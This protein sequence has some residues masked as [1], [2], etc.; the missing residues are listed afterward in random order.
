VGLATELLPAARALTGPSAAGIEPAPAR[1]RVLTTRGREQAT[2]LNAALEAAGVTPVPVPAIAIEVDPPGGE[3]DRVAGS[4][5]SYAWVVVSSADGARAILRAA[6]RILTELASPRWAAIGPA[7]TTIL[8]REG[9]EIAFR[10]S[11]SQGRVMA[12][13]LPLQAG[14]R[15]LVVRGDLADGDLVAGLRARGAEVDDVVAYRTREAPPD[16][17]PLL[18][19]A[20]ERGPIDAVVFTSGSTVRGLV[21]LA[22]SDH[23]DLGPIPAV[24]IGPE[25][26]RAATAAG[27]RVVAVSPAQD[28]ATL[29]RTTADVLSRQPQEIT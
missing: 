13:E 19:R 6:E 1:S 25:T 14:D 20:L 17:R 21:A 15:V 11:R 23:L 10:P 27:F 7:T 18:R 24:C 16:S 12:G 5:N 9:V 29:A 8:E 28:A 3:L 2:D 26:A 4:L 22:G